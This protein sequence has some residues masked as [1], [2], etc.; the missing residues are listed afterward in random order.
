MMTC[1]RDNLLELRG[2]PKKNQTLRVWS[3]A[4]KGEHYRSFVGRKW[5]R[6][7]RGQ[8]HIHTIGWIQIQRWDEVRLGDITEADCAREGRP[9]M[10]PLVFLHTF[11]LSSKK[12]IT[13]DT[14][15]VR[16]LFHFRPCRNLHLL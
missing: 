13:V 2:A 10:T 16:V 4:R 12:N 3:D 14:L 8:G 7:W 6:V 9:D 1:F 5:I 15:A 11:L